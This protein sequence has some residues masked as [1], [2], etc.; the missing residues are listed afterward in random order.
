MYNLLK[1][2]WNDDAGYL[3]SAESFF[4]A[5]I[6]VLGLIV[7]WVALRDAVVDELIEVANAFTALNQSY[8]FSGLASTCGDATTAGS[9]AIDTNFIQQPSNVAPTPS[10]ISV[11]CP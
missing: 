3:L 9:A 6:L 1:R 4:I 8:S 2:L 10:T 7:G 5:T 11:T